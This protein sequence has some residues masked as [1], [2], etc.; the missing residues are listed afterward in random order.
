MVAADNNCG[1]LVGSINGEHFDVII[2]NVIPHFRYSFDVVGITRMWVPV[3]Q[4]APF[5]CPRLQNLYNVCAKDR[6]LAKSKTSHL[7]QLFLVL[8]SS[9]LHA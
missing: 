3:S 5:L 8:L 6:Q 1:R 2:V 9:S 7:P 4:L